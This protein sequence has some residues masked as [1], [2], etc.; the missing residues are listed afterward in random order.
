MK[1]DIKKNA[2]NTTWDTNSDPNPN[3]NPDLAPTHLNFVWKKSGFFFFNEMGPHYNNNSHFIKIS[4]I[5]TL[6]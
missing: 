6:S 1:R 5:S 3:P 4:P 2:Q